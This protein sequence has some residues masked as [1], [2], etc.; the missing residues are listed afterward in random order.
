[1]NYRP[2]ELDQRITIKRET[3]TKTAMGGQSVSLVNIA[4]VFAKVTAKSGGESNKYQRLDAEAS[5]VFVIRNTNNFNVRESD[6]IEWRGTEYNIRFI[7][8][9]GPRPIYIEISADKGVAQ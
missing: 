7:S 8:D 4:T 3:N 1:M 9:P 6:R 2:G 5:Y